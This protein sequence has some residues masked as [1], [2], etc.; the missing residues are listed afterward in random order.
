MPVS[1]LSKYIA[2]NVHFSKLTKISFCLSF[3]TFPLH[4]LFLL[5]LLIFPLTIYRLFF[6]MFFSYLHLHIFFLQYSSLYF[7]QLHVSLLYY[8]ISFM[9]YIIIYLFSFTY[10]YEDNIMGYICLCVHILHFLCLEAIF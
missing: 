3:F 8:I 2:I 1:A 5:K 9:L 10:V 7:Q 6:F 4:V